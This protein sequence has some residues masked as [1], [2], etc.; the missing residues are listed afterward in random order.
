MKLRDWTEE[1]RTYLHT[2]CARGYSPRQSLQTLRLRW[3]D[4]HRYSQA[5]IRDYLDSDEAREAIVPIVQKIREEA[6]EHAYADKGSRLSLL[7]E[8]AT[9]LANQL[10]ELEREPD[11]KD[12]TAD[13]TKPDPSKIAQ[14]S[15]ELRQTLAAMQ[16]EQEPLSDM[17]LVS[18]AQSMADFFSKEKIDL[19]EVRA[20]MERDGTPN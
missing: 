17:V 20:R 9:S 18:P 7:N 1:Q 5:A 10:R 14:L 12:I 3:P 16:K 13:L 8:R 15:A 4:A 19:A 2:L 6:M 11:E